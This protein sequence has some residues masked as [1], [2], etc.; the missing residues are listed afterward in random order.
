MNSQ[1]T[2]DLAAAV[3][4]QLTA[5]VSPEIALMTLLAR[6]S[7]LARLES[8]LAAAAAGAP[9]LAARATRMGELLA[10]HADGCR[11]VAAIQRTLESAPADAAGLAAVYDG[12]ARLD[13]AASVALY[14]FGDPHLLAEATAEAVELID[15]LAPPSPAQRMLDLGCGMGRI[16]TALAPRVRRLDALELSPAMAALAREALAG[17]ANAAVETGDAADLSAWSDAVFDLVLAV[18]MWPH[19][20]A[21]RS[22]ERTLAEISRVLAP[23][24]AF[25]VLNYSWDGDPTTDAAEFGA[26]AATAGLVLEVGPLRSRRLWDACGW[27]ARRPD[28]ES[29]ARAARAR[30]RRERALALAD[31]R[32]EERA[33]RDAWSWRLT[34]PLRA[35]LDWLRTARR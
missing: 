15:R 30:E 12:A 26:R 25:V 22:E 21:S 16:A 14:T 17:H 18:D 20:R 33:L 28:P 29:A 19:V 24:G 4:Q 2:F 27:L 1:A 34:S 3:R 31:A 5:A 23:G 8:A 35:A 32:R 11:R 13:A 6:E 9:P 7:D 10:R